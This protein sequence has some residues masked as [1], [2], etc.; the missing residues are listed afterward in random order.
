MCE[1]AG[2]AQ[3]GYY[4]WRK[5]ADRPTTPGE[6]RRLPT[7]RVAPGEHGGARVGVRVEVGLAGVG[8]LASLVLVGHRRAG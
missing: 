1:T 4:A 2:V 7:L 3:S 6:Q 5:R 8:H